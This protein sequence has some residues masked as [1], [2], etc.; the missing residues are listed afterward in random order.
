MRRMWMVVPAVALVLVLQARTDEAKDVSKLVGTWTVSGE[1]SGGTKVAA[2]KFKGKEVKITRDTITCNDKD[3]KCEMAARYEIDTSA[4]PWKI[5]MTC[6]EGEQKGKEMKG[7]VQLE[8]DNLKLCY[9]KPD[10]EA[11]TKFD[12]KEGQCCVTLQRSAR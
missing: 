7:V 4:T 11:P 10:G 2:D 9:A 8:G 6:T 1:E 5:K 3:G 12:T